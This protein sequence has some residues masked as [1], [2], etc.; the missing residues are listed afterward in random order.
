MLPM[1]VFLLNVTAPGAQ[2]NGRTIPILENT[3]GPYLVEIRSSHPTPS[4]GKLHLNIVLWT[5]EAIEPVNHATV[6]IKALGPGTEPLILGP[7]DAYKTPTYSNW[8]EFNI[9]LYK[10]GEWVFTVDISE[11]E[12]LTSFDFPI[13]VK[14]IALNWMLMILFATA[15]PIIAMITWR[16]RIYFRIVNFEPPH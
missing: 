12:S 3:Q 13:H 7:F 4:I 1:I 16:L 5:L 6:S 10:E 15:I 2:A 9:E 11:E 8:Y 14:D